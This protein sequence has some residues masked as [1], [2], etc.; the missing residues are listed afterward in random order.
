MGQPE[1]QH[2]PSDL[3]RLDGKVAIGTGASSGI[4]LRMAATLDA[5][6]ATVILAARRIER[7]E[8]AT[9]EMR[10]GVPSGAT[11]PTRP[12]SND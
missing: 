12:I 2:S 7:L 3:F 6:G 8:S 1:P 4:G 9:S 10:R 5:A 11:S